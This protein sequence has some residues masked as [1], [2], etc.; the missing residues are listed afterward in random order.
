MAW[1][2]YP[3][4]IAKQAP[5]PNGYVNQSRDKIIK[6][7]HVWALEEKLGRPLKPWYEACHHCDVRNCIEPEHLF[8]GTHGDNMKDAIKK[9]RVIPYGRHRRY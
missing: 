1:Q 7:A 9:G 5:C 6:G 3:C 4:K 2:E 8:E